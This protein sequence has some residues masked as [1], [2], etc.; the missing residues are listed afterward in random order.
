MI[1]YFSS[2]LKSTCFSSF[3]SVSLCVFS[4]IPSK[5]ETCVTV[6]NHRMATL[7]WDPN[8]LQRQ[9]F[10]QF[11]QSIIYFESVHV[12]NSEAKS[13]YEMWKCNDEI[14]QS[15][16]KNYIRNSLDPEFQFG[17]TFL[18]LEVSKSG[19]SLLLEDPGILV[20]GLFTWYERKRVK[21]I[22]KVDR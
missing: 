15:S 4:E 7:V 13:N 20:S 12:I 16:Y 21:R 8:F 14:H 19:R 2:T 18:H 9:K 11:L 5:Y 3:E 10:W 1:C 6:F 17:T 22:L